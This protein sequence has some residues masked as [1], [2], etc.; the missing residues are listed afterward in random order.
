MTLEHGMTTAFT[1]VAVAR[2]H[3]IVRFDEG[4]AVAP[5]G[6]AVTRSFNR[7]SRLTSLR[8]IAPEVR[9]ALADEPLVR[10]AVWRRRVGRS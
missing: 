9:Q 6:M 1:T 7:A 5:M 4:A 8:R 10:M 2:T 3:A